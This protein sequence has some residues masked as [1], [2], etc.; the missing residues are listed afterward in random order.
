MERSVPWGEELRRP[1]R[2]GSVWQEGG[3]R[4]F[5]GVVVREPVHDIGVADV[6]GMRFVCPLRRVGER[7]V[8]RFLEAQNAGGQAA[9]GVMQECC[10]CL[11]TRWLVEVAL[12]GGNLGEAH[13]WDGGIAASPATADF[14]G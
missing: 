14:G 13:P 7:T 11:D 9:A 12:G 10:C 8:G 3:G 4:A 5:G 6:R 2:V 1:R